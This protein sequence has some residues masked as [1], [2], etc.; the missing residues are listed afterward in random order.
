MS[1]TLVFDVEV[2]ANLAD[3][4]SVLVDVVVEEQV[5]AAILVTGPEGPQGPPGSGSF[6][7]NQAAAASTW[8]VSHTLGRVPNSVSVVIGGQLVHTDVEFPD[9]FTVVVTFASPQA[10]SLRLT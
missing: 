1:D 4:E 2:A 6:I 3:P 7:H 9:A 5:V 10:G 8:I